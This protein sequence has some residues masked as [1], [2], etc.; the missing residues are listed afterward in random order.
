MTKFIRKGKTITTIATDEKPKV[1]NKF[2]SIN[3]AKRAS[4]ALQMKH[5]SGLGRGVLLCA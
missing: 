3:D 4:H 2:G 5:D 1:V